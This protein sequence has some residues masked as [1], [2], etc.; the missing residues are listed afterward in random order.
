MALQDS[1]TT[2]TGALK[3]D[4]EVLGNIHKQF[5]RIATRQMIR[6][7]SFQ[8]A[9]AI[10]GVKAVSGMVRGSSH[11]FSIYI[12]RLTRP[13]TQVVSYFSSSLGLPD[14]KVETIDADHRQM[15]KC[16]GKDD[17]RYQ[18]IFGVLKQ[19]LRSGTEPRPT[20]LDSGPPPASS[21]RSQ[22]QTGGVP[23]TELPIRAVSRP[24]TEGHASNGQ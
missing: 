3:V 9:R 7:H 11:G 24:S 6:L 2:I 17:D 19:F 14:E 15:V 23:A 18:A 10:S 20:G 16:T 5:I 12:R 1:N 13:V 22:D 21:S 4:S 8:E